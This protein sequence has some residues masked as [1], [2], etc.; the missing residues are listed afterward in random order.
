MRVAEGEMGVARFPSGQSNAR[1]TEYHADTNIRGYDDKA[2]W[3]SSFV[4]WCLA[5]VGIRGTGSALARSWLEWG[6]ALDQPQLGCIAVLSRDDPASWR[7]H[8]GFFLRTDAQYV[9][10]LGGNQLDQVC[11]LAYPL[12]DVL[13]YRWPRPDDYA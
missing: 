7:G 13:G 3:C 9:Y 8:V 4:N 2:S 11:E 1:I 10:L 12:A 6:Q 5:E